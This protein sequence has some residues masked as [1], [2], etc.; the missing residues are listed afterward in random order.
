M[1]MFKEKGKYHITNMYS[2][3]HL[4][5]RKRYFDD[6]RRNNVFHK[7]KNINIPHDYLKRKDKS[8]EKEKINHL[9]K[10]LESYKNRLNYEINMKDQLLQ[11][12]G[13]EQ[14]KN[15]ILSHKMAKIRQLLN[16]N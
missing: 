5:Y 1:F 12:L 11:Q 10:E 13:K 9:S 3:D 16:V 14:E 7:Q 15:R 8:Y 2:N 6:E 4:Q